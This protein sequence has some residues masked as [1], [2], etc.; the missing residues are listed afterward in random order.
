MT[1]SWICMAH[2]VYI[3][4]FPCLIHLLWPWLHNV[5]CAVGVL[6]HVEMQ[7]C[8]ITY[9]PANGAVCSYTAYCIV[10]KLVGGEGERGRETEINCTTW[11][12][13]LPLKENCVARR[14]I[15]P[16]KSFKCIKFCVVYKDKYCNNYRSTF[17]SVFWKFMQSRTYGLSLYIVCRSC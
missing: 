6:W 11:A 5:P 12:I 16:A 8:F 2:K 17:C 4:K 7:K 10:H 15:F 14:K 9:A 13:I 1:N 3:H